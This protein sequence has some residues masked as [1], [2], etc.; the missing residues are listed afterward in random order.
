MRRVVDGLAGWITYYQ[1]CG[2]G[3]HYDEHVFYQHVDDLAAGRGWKVLQQKQIAGQGTP[4]APSTVDFVIYRRPGNQLSREGLLFLE[5]KYFRGDNPTQDLGYLW[6]DIT[7]LRPLVPS[8]LVSHATL[9]QCGP[10]AKFL[11]VV[12]QVG[13]LQKTLNCNPRI[14]DKVKAHRLLSEAMKEEPPKGIY[15]AQPETYL[16]D[17]L[18]WR[19]MAISS[20]N[21]PK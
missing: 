8:G 17:N 10:P 11:L 1:A 9:T 12:G 5:M 14:Q 19:V 6:D 21:W 7:K 2:T 18:R 20:R 15:W 16:R 13:D 4:G 3:R